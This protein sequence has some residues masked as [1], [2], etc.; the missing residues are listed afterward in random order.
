LL[1]SCVKKPLQEPFYHKT[2]PVIKCVTF[3]GV[4]QAVATLL[5]LSVSKKVALV[6]IF[7]SLTA[8]CIVTIKPAW[9]SAV[10]DSWV[11]KVPMQE[12]RGDLDIFA[13]FQIAHGFTG[14]S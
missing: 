5:K 14:R 6:L 8:L 2:N 11:S 10:L 7:I 13:Y 9:A 4:K 3:E 12:V 1:V